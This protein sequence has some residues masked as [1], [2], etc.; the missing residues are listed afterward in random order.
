MQDPT[1]IDARPV[2]DHVIENARMWLDEYRVDGLR[3][4]AVHAIADA[5]P[6]HIEPLLKEVMELRFE[7]DKIR[8]ALTTVITAHYSYEDKQA[9]LV[10]RQSSIDG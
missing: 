1:V 9:G 4:D 7:N 3:L 2:R 8:Q 10:A 6:R 5:S